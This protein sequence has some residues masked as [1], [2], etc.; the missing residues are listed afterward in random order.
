MTA[1]I[2]ACRFRYTCVMVKVLPDYWIKPHGPQGASLCLKFQKPKVDGIRNVQK[3]VKKQRRYL[4]DMV[5]LN[6]T[7]DK[8][9]E[10]LSRVIKQKHILLN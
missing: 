2:V 3:V 1:T 9:C 7:A 10:V 8:I 6:S 4:G 5:I